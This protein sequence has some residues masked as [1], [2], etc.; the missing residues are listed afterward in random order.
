MYRQKT[1][2]VIDHCATHTLRMLISL[3]YQNK[4]TKKDNEEKSYATR[5]RANTVATYMF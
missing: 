5:F 4:Q 1:I 2:V 3:D